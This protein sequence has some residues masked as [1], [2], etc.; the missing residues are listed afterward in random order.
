MKFVDPLALIAQQPRQFV[1]FAGSQL[2]GSRQSQE[3]FFINFND[4]CVVVTDGASKRHGD[5]AAKLAAETAM[6]GYKHIRE[7]PFYWADKKLFLKRI[8][9]S[10]NIAVWQKKREYGFESGLASSLAVAII[11]VQRIWVAAV[12]NS[13][14]LLY[15]DGLIDVLTP[16]DS[17]ALGLNR[18]GL[19]PHVAAERFLARDILLLATDGIT[20]YVSEDQL[21]ATFEVS[22]NSTDSLTTAITHLLRTAQENG[23]TDNMTACMIKKVRATEKS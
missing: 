17:K 18:F 3:D 6:W 10:A 14:V 7:R 21:R 15:R 2:Q 23:S 1:L 13:G 22:G 11:G 19:V 12:G 5:I 8:F 4:E 9:R 16:L 20:N